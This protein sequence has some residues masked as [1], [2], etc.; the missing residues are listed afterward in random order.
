MKLGRFLVSLA[1]MAILAGVAYVSQANEPSGAKMAGA[2]NRFLSSLGAEQKARATFDF[3]NKE[4]LNWHFVPL[5]D[6]QKNSTRKGLP[7]ADMSVEQQ[8]AAKAL[9]RSGT[10]GPGFLQ[11]TTIMSL[12]SILKELENGSMVRN[13]GWYFFTIFG[14]PSKTGKWGWR[15]EGHHLSL[16]FTLNGGKVIAS[17]PAFF[18]ANPA[19][20]QRGPR[21]G[22]RTIPQAEDLA[23]ELFNSLDDNQKTIALQGKQFPEIDGKTK[24]P[25]AGKPKG[26][27]AAQMTEKQRELLVKLVQSYASRMPSDVAESEMS[28]VEKSG[29]EQIHFAFAGGLSAGEPHTYRIQ[30]PT[31]LIEFLNVQADSAR[32]PS[33]HIHSAWRT[34]AGDFGL[35]N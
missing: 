19:T 14:T 1:L 31:F 6:A 2:A 4:R 30:G 7:L 11:A 25:K 15:V 24:A 29:I 27:P 3:D 21:K 34:I 12:E 18:G 9:L 32:N 23:K 22:L 5:Q 26:L 17:T 8:A 16:N 33:N 28:H 10:S 20:V 35:P 13:P